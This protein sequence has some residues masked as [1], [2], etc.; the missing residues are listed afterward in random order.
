M[1]Y[2]IPDIAGGLRA[3]R[4]Q[5]A[6]RRDRLMARMM[7]QQNIRDKKAAALVKQSQG[8]V[9]DFY[10]HFESQPKSTDL[11]FNTAAENFVRE[12]A[13][14]Q[15]QAYEL[16]YGPNGNAEL[17]ANYNAQVARDKREL[18]TIGEWMVLGNAGNTQIS[19]N[20]SATQKN[21]EVGRFTRS[22]SNSIGEKFEFQT[23]LEGANFS[24]LSLSS[25]E[26]G[27]VTLT[28]GFSEQGK[29]PLSRNLSSDVANAKKGLDW[30]T[31]IEE[32]DKLGVIGGKQWNVGVKDGSNVLVKPL[33]DEFEQVDKT[34]TIYNPKDDT[35]KITKT[36][37]YNKE[38]IIN[39]LTDTDNDLSKR[40]N[41]IINSENF[42]KQW[43][44]LYRGGY[45]SS[46]NDDNL[47][48][49][50]NIS[51]DMVAKMRNLSYADMY[52]QLAPNR[53]EFPAG[54]KGD[55]KFKAA[56]QAFNEFVKGVDSDGNKILDDNERQGFIGQMQNAAR[57]GLAN[58]Y[59][60]QLAPAS[61]RETIEV[62]YKKGRY[63][64]PRSSGGL[65]ADKQLKL[66][67]HKAALEANQSSA[68]KIIA[69]D[70][71]D[72]ESFADAVT[73]ALKT[74]A[75]FEKTPDG[76]ATMARNG[77]VT[78]DQANDMLDAS[79]QDNV[80]LL[81]GALYRMKPV[82]TT[83]EGE[84]RQQWE[85]TLI[86]RPELLKKALTDV[87]ALEQL[88]NDGILVDLEASTLFHANQVELPEG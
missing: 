42:E 3:R 8:E 51:W 15:E 64:P 83:V 44:Q 32:S 81:D 47:K 49:F 62:I 61:D 77:Y 72:L 19:N 43:D 9:A 36:K 17:R 58:Y 7:Q 65:S 22:S 40:L 54:E 55:E 24:S 33:K 14:A 27:N 67:T 68:N 5:S 10:T 35:T 74:N 6:A 28:G 18:V 57:H 59:A 26:N 70:Y 60:E 69:A 41:P 73:K 80:Q 82:Y 45:I 75:K 16:A 86:A 30:F 76:K 84:K 13:M 39:K 46:K 11:M 12:K 4:A 1:A 87:K 48:N 29:E 31:S 34:Y 52:K 56:E 66:S 25:D 88:L 85:P 38:D 53:N 63:V 78:S 71:K 37:E 21:I 2:Q 23:N 79:N 20:A 50:G